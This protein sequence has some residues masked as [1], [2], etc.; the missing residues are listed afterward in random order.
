MAL[1]DPTG[2]IVAAND[3]LAAL[4]GDSAGSLSGRAFV[5]LLEETGPAVL[6]TGWEAL[7]AGT[8]TPSTADAHVLRG[9]GTSVRRTLS[10]VRADA[11]TVLVQLLPADDD[12]GST[13]ARQREA[14]LRL[15]LEAGRMGVW[16]WDLLT[17]VGYMSPELRRLHGIDG[18][19]A[20]GAL[21]GYLTLVHP[22]DR[23]AVRNAVSTGVTSGTG[24]SIEYR[25]IRPDGQLRWMLGKGSTDRDGHGRIVLLSGICV[26]ITDRKQVEEDLRRQ[27]RVL[28]SMSEGVSVSDEAGVILYTNPAEDRLFGYEPGELIGKHVTVQNTYPPEENHRRVAEVIDRLRRHGMWEGEFSNVRKDGTRFTTFSRITALETDGRRYWV[29]VQQDVSARKA[30]EEELRRRDERHRA[31]LATSTEAIW[32]FE[33]DQPVPASWPAERQIDAFFNGAYLAECNDAMA[34]MYG[35][36]RADELVGARLHEMIVRDSEANQEYLRQFVAS[37]YRLTG[38]ETIEVDRHGQRRVFRNS[39]VGILEDGCVVRA[40][41]TQMDIT[42]MRVARER[43]SFLAAAGKVLTSSLDYR[44]TLT[45]IANLAVPFLAD[46]CAVDMLSDDGRIERLAVAHPDPQRLARVLELGERWPPRLDAPGSFGEVVRSRQA[47]MV[48][49]IT[50]EM[51]VAGARDADHLELLQSLGL[52]SA[53]IVPFVARNRVLGALTLALSESGRRYEEAHLRIAE[54]LA[55]RAAMAI[56]NSRLYEDAQTAS[57]AKDDFMARLSHELRTPLNAALGWTHMLQISRQPAQLERGL[58]VI[59]RNTRALARIIEDLLDFSRNMRGSL[60]LE[61]TPIDLAD[62]VRQAV[63][64]VEPLAAEKDIRL[65][66]TGAD[67]VALSGDAAR[68]QQV[69]W[70]LLTNAIKFT[71]VRGSIDVQVR[72]TAATGEIVVTDTGEGIRPELLK[73]IFD[74]FRQGVVQ[75]SGGLGL[76]LA[77]VRQIVEAHE[78]EVHAVSHGPGAGASFV[79]SLPLAQTVEG[80]TL[81]PAE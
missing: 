21:D 11:G 17:G 53:M 18:D 56:D 41:G 80:M 30:A 57:R 50:P 15:A 4:T 36:D 20:P 27:A 3:A 75:S 52:R 67:T 25:I 77:I 74:P 64:S 12:A 9:D 66:F 39:L 13:A 29:C 8:T 49:D 6:H 81:A 58:A 71:P 47:L 7:L 32:R 60:R 59:D 23:D 78:G 26:D 34:R 28:E 31:F 63:V 68:L 51:L 61:R 19:F 72:R 5:D 55:S 33:I 38:Y 69:V 2:R 73:V 45:R 54:E 70:N 62:V 16:H 79:V 42:D 44:Q 43:E 46:W 37:G 10:L 40:W 14:A 35:F 65:G 48:R 1:L 24:H 22:E 76:G